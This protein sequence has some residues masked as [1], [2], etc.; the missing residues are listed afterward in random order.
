MQMGTL[1]Q[2]VLG[3]VES[4]A[5]QR[6]TGPAP[7]FGTP[8]VVGPVGD[9]EALGLVDVWACVS[10]IAS[11]ASTLPLIAYRRAV[12]GRERLAGGRLV[13]LLRSPAP[14]T[15]L[16]NLIGQ[17][18]ASLA[19]RGNAYL[20]LYADDTGN[21]GQLGVIDPARLQ[22]QIVA[23]APVYVLTHLD[24]RQTRHDSSDLVHIKM[25][26]SLDGVVG[27]SPVAQCRE[28]LGLARALTQEA[29]ALIQN[30]T[31]PRGVLSVAAGPASDDVLQN[32]E[33]SFTSR[34]QGPEK[35]GRVAVLSSDVSFTALSLSPH[36]A[37][38]V[39]Q[40]K[41]STQEIAR[42]FAVPPWML[43]APSND[44]LTYS[45]T[46][47]QAAAFVKFCLAPYLAAI[48]QAITASPLCSAATTYVEFLVDALL[49]P[50]ALTRAQVYA[51]A[52]DPDKGWMRRDEVRQRE[53]L[54][55]EQAAA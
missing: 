34:H 14:G 38:F 55:P 42:L 22:V 30:A 41:L 27:L 1:L 35:A 16:A 50:D 13:E 54:P 18:C 53:N 23:G 5:L 9:R 4:R 49:R 20:G 36:D 46:E 26:L 8:V 32:L 45:N 47:M 37:E 28:A 44:S 52:L 19:L 39:E 11:V 2:R 51:L 12:D 33:S 17:L 7:I 21:V 25:P 3:C 48:E 43:N 15:T 29:T 10:I 24:G 6:E 31:A 40:R